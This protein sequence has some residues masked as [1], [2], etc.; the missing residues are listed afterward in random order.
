MTDNNFVKFINRHT[1]FFYRG[2]NNDTKINNIKNI[3]IK[4][5]QCYN[6][7]D[8]Y[9]VSAQMNSDYDNLIEINNKLKINK[10][11][12]F[13][14]DIKKIKKSLFI[15]DC[16]CNFNYDKIK[17]LDLTNFI[18]FSYD[19][20]TEILAM[21]KFIYNGSLDNLCQIENHKRSDLNLNIDFND[22]KFTI[23]SANYII[24]CVEYKRNNSVTDKPNEF[25]DKSNVNNKS[26]ENMQDGQSTGSKT[27]IEL[28]PLSSISANTLNVNNIHNL[29][30][31]NIDMNEFKKLIDELSNK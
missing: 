22:L 26:T 12:K 10:L 5:S 14:N 11:N 19:N 15:V 1:E 20:Y 8:I 3:I 24:T 21:V 17:E 4:F 9:I 7:N 27:P 2:T 29:H 18:V 23:N 6:L 28:L 31:T 13:T 16:S 30:M 25:V